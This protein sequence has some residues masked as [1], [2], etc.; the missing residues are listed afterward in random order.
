M[1]KSLQKSQNGFTLIELVVV[2]AILGLLAI[3]VT[4]RV[5]GAVNNARNNGNMSSAKQIQV[6]LE[7]INSETGTY[8]TYAALCGANASACDPVTMQGRL[9]D[10]A[11]I[12]TNFTATYTPTPDASPTAYTLVIT[13][14]D[15]P[16][17][18]TITGNAITTA[19]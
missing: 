7:R 11:S 13:F 14:T 8:P 17:I 1:H 6:A 12:G 16:R 5:M 4:P 15:S 2:V 9:R 10:H 3:V 18:Y 19:N